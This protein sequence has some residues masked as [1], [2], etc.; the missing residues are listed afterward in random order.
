MSKYVKYFNDMTM[1]KVL[2]N[3]YFPNSGL[4]PHIFLM[5]IIIP[6]VMSTLY[7]MFILLLVTVDHLNAASD[8]QYR[9]VKDFSPLKSRSPTSAE[10]KS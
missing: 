2:M 3:Q 7:F 10:L 5:V 9:H 8:P 1:L 4:I 6:L